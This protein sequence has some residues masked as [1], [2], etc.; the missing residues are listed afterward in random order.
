M[1]WSA[2]RAIAAGFTVALVI[3]IIVGVASYRNAMELRDASAFE[4]RTQQVL[5]DLHDVMSALKDVETA[6]RGYSL[7]GET[8]FLRPYIVAV[9]R[10]RN[11]MAR[12]AREVL[13]PEVRPAIVELNVLVEAKIRMSD[14][15]IQLRR[16]GSRDRAEQRRLLV[17]GREVMD[18]IRELSGRLSV[19]EFRLLQDRIVAAQD[20]QRRTSLMLEVGSTCAILF[21]AFAMYVIFKDLRE[22]RRIEQQ[23]VQ[24]TTLQ[25]AILHG[26]GSSIVAM[27]RSGTITSFNR[28]AE[29]MLGYGSNQ[30]IGKVSAVSFLD[31]DE[32]RA[33]AE[34]LSRELG[35]TVEPGFDALVAKARVGG[36]DQNEWTCI[37]KDGTRFPALLSVTAL[38]NQWGDITGYLGIGSDIT[39]LKTA[40]AD[41]RKAEARFRALIQGSNDIVAM[42]APSGAMLYVS[43]AIEPTIGYRPSEVIGK[44]VFDFLHPGDL[45]DAQRS[46]QKTLSAPGMA[47]PLQARLR[48][49][50]GEYHWVEILANNLLHDPDL[51]AVVINARDISDRRELERRSA[52]Q[53]S[54]TAVL[55]DA[56]TLSE[57]TAR[58]LAAICEQMGYDL[59]EVWQVDTEAHNLALIE[60]WQSRAITTGSAPEFTVGFRLS[61]GQGVPG[62]VWQSGDVLV[63]PDLASA[64]FNLRKEKHATLGLHIAF[65][66]PITFG[67]DVIA[68]MNF[69]S[70]ESSVPDEPMV[71]IFRSLGIQIG[72]FMARKRAEESAD[73]LRRQTQLILE[74]AGEGIIG[75]N[76]R[77]QIT[78]INPA[79]ERM[80]AYSPGELVGRE[81]FLALHPTRPDGVAIPQNE[82]PIFHA[83]VDGSQRTSAEGTFWRKN[84]TSFPAQYTGSP[85]RTDTGITGAVVTFQDVT[86]RREID[87]MKDEFISVVSHELRTP[88]TS[89]R[90]AL[91]LLAGG[92]VGAFPEK[93]Q[94]MLDIAV[95]NTDRLVRL[96]NDILDIE[97]IDSGRVTMQ[98]RE[99]EIG[100]LMAQAVEVMR[101]MGD[102]NDVALELNPVTATVLAD[103][104]RMIQTF[105]NLISNA[106]KFSPASS[107]VTLSGRTN[108]DRVHLTVTDHG[109]G[110]PPEKLQSIFERFQ[111][112]DASDSREKGGTGLGL[113]I[114]RTIIHQHDGEIWAESKLGEGSSFH[115]VL[116]LAEATPS[117]ESDHARGA[118]VLLCDDDA[119][120]REVVGHLLEQRG[121]HVRA[122]GSGTEAIRA[123]QT[124]PPELIILDLLMP[125]MSG[126]Q[127][128]DSLKADPATAH[129]PVVI[130]SVI[131]PNGDGSRK[132]AVAGWVTKPLEE[133]QLFRTLSHALRSR[134]A[135]TRVLIVEDDPELS[136]LLDS[137]L[138]HNQIETRVARSGREA[139]QLLPEFRPDL[140]VLDVVFPL[141]DG[142]SV[143]QWMRQ[144]EKFRDLPVMVYSGRELSSEE[145]ARL[146]VGR[147]QFFTKAATAPNDFEQ[148][149]LALLAQVLPEPS[150]QRDEEQNG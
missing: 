141:G 30:V 108:S 82:T 127:V 56:E 31:H 150:R 20:A 123:A 99:V 57:A 24:T 47:D 124:E 134:S 10:A 45:P 35:T 2:E 120:V 86:R 19:R 54:V 85:I 67:D 138:R 94:R 81:V 128:V 114:C 84:G 101:P 23:L 113:A 97:R 80:L 3:L 34:L 144:S 32:L 39:E 104:D 16:S 115:V 119:A 42:L 142:F 92:R 132:N 130:F 107:K 13:E 91:G 46:F 22:R 109:R 63:V 9:P 68:V 4:Q 76:P 12:L 27:D 148:H 72:N 17:R 53:S 73:R 83:L 100:D 133:S 70:R 59:G 40:Q 116:P 137:M 90:G 75:I 6:S 105:T 41:L 49:P 143:V 28:A 66:V 58:I 44:N 79:G 125:S 55:A 140:V 48:G 15:Q 71:R 131:R 121:F 21:L 93:A 102:K 11:S 98:K 33:R 18:R 145:R 43:P 51:R 26:A 25:N 95:N 110:I 38:R 112:V 5:D 146:T 52:L 136:F 106:I 117:P 61:T 139:I 147:T 74:S 111:Q 50:D 36:V 96:I 77:Y 37:R 29:T 7:T 88:L 89:I 64:G 87:R 129:I 149:V 65:G 126:W 14:E 78:F 62:K 8:P 103:P 1:R 60:H 69:A 135:T 122:V 118:T